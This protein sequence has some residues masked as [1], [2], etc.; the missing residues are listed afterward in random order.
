M[1]PRKNIQKIAALSFY[2]S[3]MVETLNFTKKETLT[4]IF[5]KDFN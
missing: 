3:C 2:E 1:K 4:Q 5:F